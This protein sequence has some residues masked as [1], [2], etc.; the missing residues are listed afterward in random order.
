M[1][2]L[3]RTVRLSGAT[4]LY[5]QDPKHIELMYRNLELD[6]ASSRA[7]RGEKPKHNADVH[8]PE[9]SREAIVAACLSASMISCPLTKAKRKVAFDPHVPDAPFLMITRTILGSSS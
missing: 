8:A 9:H 1:C 3:N 2:A 5:T 6:G 4:I 7:T